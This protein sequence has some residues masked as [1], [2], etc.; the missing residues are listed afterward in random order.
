MSLPHIVTRD[1]W[2]VARKEL[3][4]REKELTIAR[5]TLN[6]D[7]RRLPMVLI[8][9]EYT[10]DGP[11]GKVTLIDLFQGRR[12]LIV[13]HFMFGPT[14]EE[15]CAACT[16]AADEISSGLLDHLAV[17]DTTL[18]VV[19]RAPLAKLEQYR[20]RR[21]WAF[22]LYSSWGSDFNYDFHVSFDPSIAPVEYNYRA[23]R[24]VDED[25][26]QGLSCFLRDGDRVFH[27]YSA[28]ARGTE[29]GN[30]SYAFLDLTALGRQEDWEE[31]KGRV[32]SPH[33][34]APIFTN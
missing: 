24:Y 7:R 23:A 12:Q 5:D 30:P 15:G 26:E 16:S 8:D 13:Q 31:P 28:F 4:A 34:A 20:E 19:A 11:Q 33:G 18:A 6:A 17:R 10:F 14:W 1:E 29:L 2:L 3:L 22:P 32:T 25:E 9:K 27:T 21:G